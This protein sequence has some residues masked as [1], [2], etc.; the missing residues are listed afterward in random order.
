MVG[1]V[2]LVRGEAGIG[3]SRLVGALTELAEKHRA[4]FTQCQCSPFYQQTALISADRSAGTNSPS[5]RAAR[6]RGAEAP[7]TGRLLGRERPATGRHDPALLKPVVHSDR[8]QSASANTAPEQQKQQ[9]MRALMTIP[10]RRAAQ[11]PVVLHHG[12]SALGRSDHVGVAGH[13]GRRDPH[14]AHHGGADLS[15]R[16][17]PAMD[18]QFQCHPSGYQSLAE[19]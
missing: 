8:R 17:Q 13:V 1:Q 7:Q 16:L 14:D 5:V 18:R 10:F 15:P 6:L 12:R 4:W 19:R 2:V 11:Q 3:K 9:T